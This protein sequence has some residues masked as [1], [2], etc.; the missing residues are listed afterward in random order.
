MKA[1]CFFAIF[2]I[3]ASFTSCSLFKKTNTATTDPGVVINGVRWATRN[4][5]ESGTFAPTPES[6]GKFYQ[7]NRKKA[8]NTTDTLVTGWDSSV[9][10]GTEWEKANDPSPTGWHVPTQDEIMSLFGKEV[11]NEWVIQ[12]GVAG[13]KFTDKINGNSVFFPAA[14][15]R[16]YGKGVL[17]GTNIIGYYWSSQSYMLRTADYL[18]F[19]RMGASEITHGGNRIF[20]QPLRSVAE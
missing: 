13:R 2:I 8:W 16:T 14:G 6:A 7:W 18:S 11:I 3:I 17:N 19:S 5:D 10:E 9:P 20:G 1:K 15:Y 12:N 4:V